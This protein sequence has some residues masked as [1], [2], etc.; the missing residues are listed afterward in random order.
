MNKPSLTLL[1]TPSEKQKECNHPLET[2]PL[3]TLDYA[4]IQ[5]HLCYFIIMTNLKPFSNNQE[6][7]TQSII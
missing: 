7:P 6:C 4:Q 2:R 3:Q 5:T 1:T